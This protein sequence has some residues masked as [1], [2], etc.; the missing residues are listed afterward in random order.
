MLGE[1]RGCRQGCLVGFGCGVTGAACW[2]LDG[3]G[4]VLLADKDLKQ[5]QFG[6]DA[7]VLLVLVQHGDAVLLLY[8]PIGKAVSWSVERLCGLFH[9]EAVILN[10]HCI[11]VLFQQLH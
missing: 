2:T 8:V 3:F 5:A 1:V 11:S 4:G 10:K 6:F 9:P 7:F